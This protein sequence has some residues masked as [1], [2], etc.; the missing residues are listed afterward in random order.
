MACAKQYWNIAGAALCGVGSAV[1]I[2]ASGILTGG[3]AGAA[4][5]VSVPTAIASGLGLLGSIAWL[6]S[7][8]MDLSDC[9]EAN[10]KPDEAARFR[11]QAE[12]LQRE[13]DE[14]KRQVEQLQQ[15]VH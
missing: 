13:H 1:G 10:G 2:G 8:I 6:I 15:M 12:Q 3:T 11:Q 5:P 7:G 14:L 9:L 4:T